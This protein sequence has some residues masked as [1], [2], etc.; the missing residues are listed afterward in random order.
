M[1]WSIVRLWKRAVGLFGDEG[2]IWTA[3]HPPP[4]AL[5]PG[6]ND[7]QMTS[8]QPHLKDPLNVWAAT[9]ELLVINVISVS[10]KTN[11]EQITI[12]YTYI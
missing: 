12:N 9:F 11:A 1:C 8:A 2:W 6:R 10:E 5:S 4:A 7:I 3:L